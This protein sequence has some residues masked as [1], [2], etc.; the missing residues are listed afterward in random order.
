MPH[1]A[2]AQNGQHHPMLR[3][4]IIQRG[5][6]NGFGFP[7]IVQAPWPFCSSESKY[8][9]WWPLL[10]Y[11]FSFTMTYKRVDLWFSNSATSF[12]YWNAIDDMFKRIKVA[13]ESVSNPEQAA[14]LIDGPRAARSTG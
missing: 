6:V 5:F 10:Q 9:L 12:P 4:H 14:T 7:D 3:V 1:Q 2:V 13:T 8:I 11:T